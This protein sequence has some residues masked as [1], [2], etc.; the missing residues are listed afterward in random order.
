V[1]A[2][3]VYIPNTISK[4][5]GDADFIVFKQYGTEMQNIQ[6]DGN[7]NVL[8]DVDIAA[9]NFATVD[10]IL[11]ELSGDEIKATGNGRLHI[12]AGTTEKPSIRGH[13]EI[14]NGKYD[15]NFQSF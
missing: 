9:N 10:V 13:Y 7:F 3:Q 15:F 11:D 6:D 8:V 14:E 5:S 1:A 12:I 2:S 4:E